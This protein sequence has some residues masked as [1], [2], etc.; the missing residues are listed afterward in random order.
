MVNQ[1]S[2]VEASNKAVAL[3]LNPL[4]AM[5]ATV[6]RALASS[7]TV[8]NGVVDKRAQMDEASAILQTPGFTIMVDALGQQPSPAVLPLPQADL[9]LSTQAMS[10]FDAKIAA[11]MDKA[12]NMDSVLTIPDKSG[13]NEVE[14]H[15]REEIRSALLL[16]QRIWMEDQV[17]KPAIRL[18]ICS[19]ASIQ[20]SRVYGLPKSEVDFIVGALDVS[21]DLDSRYDMKRS[22]IQ[23][24]KNG[25]SYS[26]MVQVAAATDPM[27]IPT[28]LN[29]EE[30]LRQQAA[31]LGTSP[32]IIY[33]PEE[34]KKLRDQIEKSA[35]EQAVLQAANPQNQQQGSA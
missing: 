7:D 3:G 1:L 10:A 33:T 18:L 15:A 13:V 35:S 11:T 5:D 4:K 9:G 16:N 17:L 27:L 19:A 31:L 20:L 12:L 25:I 29:T 23:A 26:Q 14:M 8:V 28:V 6:V 22:E 32:S 30:Y 24:Y 2:N 21:I 34:T